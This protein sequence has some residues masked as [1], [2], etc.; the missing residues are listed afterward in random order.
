MTR[1]D[2]QT[3]SVYNK[4]KQYALKKD[5][6]I[7]IVTTYMT[8]PEMLATAPALRNSSYTMI[9]D[10]VTVNYP[11]DQK[12]IALLEEFEMFIDGLVTYPAYKA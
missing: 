7:D 1:R 4:L 8:C 9:V 3:V 11:D 12:L 10:S 5:E 6:I 2:N